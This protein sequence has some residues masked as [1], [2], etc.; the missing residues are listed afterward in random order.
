[1]FDPHFKNMAIIWDFMGNAHVIQIVTYYDTNILC[2][3]LL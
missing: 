1:M 3:I 2:L